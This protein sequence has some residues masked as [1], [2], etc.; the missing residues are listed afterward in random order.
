M[1]FI[2]TGSG[3]RAAKSYERDLNGAPYLHVEYS[4]PEPTP[5]PT[6]TA[7]NTP[8][9]TPTPTA[10]DTPTPTL[11]PTP[12]F[13]PTITPTPVPSGPVTIQYTYD[14]LYRLTAADYSTG[15]Y[16]HY[17]YDAV[18][19]RL[20]QEKLVS[21]M[22]TTDSYLYDDANRILSVDGVSYAWDNNGNLQSRG[23]S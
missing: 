2:I 1:A 8:T 15:D 4:L 12:T 17:G 16:Y 23:S 9:E 10:T 6:P 22:L 19:N 5:T 11:T 7:T 18:G 13:T 14:G 21:G 20:S 3:K